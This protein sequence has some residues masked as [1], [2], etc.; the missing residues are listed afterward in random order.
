[1]NEKNTGGVDRRTFVKQ[2]GGA[3]LVAGMQAKRGSLGPVRQRVTVSYR[4][5]RFAVIVNREIHVE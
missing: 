1:M 4:A 3:M 2:A 5:I